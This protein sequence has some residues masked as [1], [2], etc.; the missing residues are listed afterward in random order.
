MTTFGYALVST[1]DQDLTAR[2]D[3]LKK[4]GAGTVYRETRVL[5][6]QF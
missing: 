3:A 2:L 4:A 6:V 1:Q 5:P